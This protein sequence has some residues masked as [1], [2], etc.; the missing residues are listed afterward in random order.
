MDDIIPIPYNITVREYIHQ[1]LYQS[2]LK[3]IYEK[4]FKEIILELRNKAVIEI[5]E[6][7]IF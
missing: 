1:G 3:D 4:A 6:E 7:Y 5:N 2:E